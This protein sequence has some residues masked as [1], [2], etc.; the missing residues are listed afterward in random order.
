MD[1]KLFIKKIIY[2]L[3]VL[4]IIGFFNYVIDAQQQIRYNNHY[5]SGEQRIINNGLARNYIYDTIIMGSST[6][7]NILKKD[8]DKLFDVNSVNLSLSG[9][10]ALEHRNLL[11]IAIQEGKV[12]NVIY[13]L[14]VF[15]YNRLGVKVPIIDYRKNKYNLLKYLFN[16][17]V[18]K[19][20]LKVIIKK[21]IGRNENNW[22]YTWSFWANDYIFSEENALTFDPN[23]HSGS[24]NLG[25]IKEA[26]KGYKYEI[27][28][29]NFD[30]LLEIIKNTPNI[31]YTIYL[32]PYSILYWYII[33]K[34]NCLQEIIKFKEY[35]F[36][37]EKEFKN[38][39]VHDFQN[40]FST[41]LNLN[42]YRDSVHFSAEISKKIIEEIKTQKFKSQNIDFE[43]Q[44]NILI[45]KNKDKF[46][47][48]F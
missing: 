12:K 3:A 42:N 26:K 44:I 23:K 45:K 30:E 13:G 10:T 5:R 40:D 6:S 25:V 33:D 21:I 29:K 20:N 22:I 35:I 14:D 34:Y 46:D 7:E 18:M 32:P 17:S 36:L 28:K 41:I 37:K 4:L 27:M 11:N 48:K 15:N 16:I 38:L 39:S 1:K 47:N 8:V 31:N 9:S 2:I 24:Q 43:S 19:S